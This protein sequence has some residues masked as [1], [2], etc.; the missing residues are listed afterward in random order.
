MRAFL[1]TA[2]LAV[3]LFNNVTGKAVAYLGE[4][5]LYKLVCML[6]SLI[7]S[8]R[9]STRGVTVFIL[10]YNCKHCTFAQKVVSFT[11]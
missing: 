7:Q 10:V 9:K 3:T 2:V 6:H 5:L 4:K 11:L 8:V 1:A